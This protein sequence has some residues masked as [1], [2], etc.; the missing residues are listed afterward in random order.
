MAAQFKALQAGG[1]WVQARNLAVLM[2]TNAGLTCAI[3]KIR[4]KEDVYSS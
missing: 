3:K 4:G 1:P 2:G